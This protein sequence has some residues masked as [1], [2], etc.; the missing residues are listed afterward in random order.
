MDINE[1][2][3]KILSSPE[4]VERL[5]E[6]AGQLFGEDTPPAPEPKQNTGFSLPEGLLG[7]IGNIGSVMKLISL[8]Q[9]R[10]D[11]DRIKLLYAIKPHLSSSRAKRVDKAISL[12]KVA[13]IVPILKQ[14]GLLDGLLGGDFL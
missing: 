8:M 11:D 2:L 10:K 9:N 7:N 4:S 1:Q 14:E 6:A 13:S 12:L 3:T 5:K